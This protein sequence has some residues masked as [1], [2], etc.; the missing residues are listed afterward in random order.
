M[1]VAWQRADGTVDGALFTRALM[2][3]IRTFRGVWH[4]E[5]LARVAPEDRRIVMVS[6]A[7]AAAEATA[8]VKLFERMRGMGLDVAPWIALL[9]YAGATVWFDKDDMF[10]D[11][12]RL[13]VEME[14]WR[15]RLGEHEKRVR[16]TQL[17]LVE[18]GCIVDGYASL[19]YVDRSLTF[20]EVLHHREIEEELVRRRAG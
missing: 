20:T 13:R 9:P 3:A 7:L 8:G 15:G 11:A 19:S 5:K 12:A 2:D 1:R 4:E 17:R 6:P 10:F 16:M 18:E 14:H